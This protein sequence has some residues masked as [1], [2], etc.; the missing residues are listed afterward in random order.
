MPTRE[1]ET[2]DDPTERLVEMRRYVVE[3]ILKKYQDLVSYVNRKKDAANV[4]DARI[5][6]RIVYEKSDPDSKEKNFFNISL[7]TM[8][9]SLKPGRDAG[10]I[11]GGAIVLDYDLPHPNMPPGLLLGIGIEDT[12]RQTGLRTFI[13]TNGAEAQFL[14]STTDFA[15]LNKIIL[16]L[17]AL[18]LRRP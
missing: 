18:P 10:T 1:Y 4:P 3:I 7:F 11:E 13:V 15:T 17:E 8:D 14:T 2:I 12:P 16:G 6:V 5:T 9:N